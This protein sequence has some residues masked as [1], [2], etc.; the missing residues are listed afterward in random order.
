[1]NLPLANRPEV[2]GVIDMDLLSVI[3]RWRFREKMALREIERR[4]GLL[5]VSQIPGQAFQ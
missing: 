1:L 2:R 3:R 4:S 5:R